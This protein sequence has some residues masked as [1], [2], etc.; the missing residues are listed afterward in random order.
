MTLLY[1]RGYAGKD[2]S[3]RWPRPAACISTRRIWPH[4]AGASFRLGCLRQ[5]GLRSLARRVPPRP[6]RLAK[7]G[8]HRGPPNGGKGGGRS[9]AVYRRAQVSSYAAAFFT[10]RSAISALACLIHPRQ[11]G[12][13][14]SA[15]LLDFKV[16]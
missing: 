4:P 5:I 13:V 15:L 9:S 14:G 11:V 2:R 10:S 12:I 3:R 1:S 6:S 8:G 16:G 7:A